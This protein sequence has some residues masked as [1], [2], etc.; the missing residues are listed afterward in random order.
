MRRRDCVLWD[1]DAARKCNSYVLK[2]D[3]CVDHFVIRSP[4]LLMG[5]LHTSPY[6]RDTN[7]AFYSTSLTDKL[8]P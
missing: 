2:G 4:N 8:I 7:L 5:E 6:C 1:E 3:R